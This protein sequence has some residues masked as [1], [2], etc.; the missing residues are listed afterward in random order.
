MMHNQTNVNLDYDYPIKIAEGIYWIGFHDKQS[1]LHCN[2]YLIIDGEEAVIIDGGSRPDFP[3]VLMKILRTGVAPSAIVALIYDHYDPDLVG[4]AHNFESIIS[5]RDLKIISD[6]ANNMFIR[7][8]YI[9]SSLTTIESLNYEFNFSSGRTL[10]FIPTPYAHAQGS[11]ITF[12]T[13]SNIAFTGD[14]FGS[15]GSNWELFFKLDE[16]C[17]RDCKNMNECQLGKSVCPLSGMIKFHKNVMPSEKALRLAI[18]KIMK[19]SAKLI[20]PQHGSIIYDAKDID[21]IS[22]MLYSLKGVGIDAL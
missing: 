6:A 3:V 9:E 1:G 20:A 15:Y 5:R 2:P 22:S 7:H 17:R 11:F 10:Q 21:Y 14:I 12:D 18:G 19:L 16:K 13:Q 8:Y 4:S